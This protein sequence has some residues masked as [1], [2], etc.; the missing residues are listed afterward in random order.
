MEIYADNGATTRLSSAALDAMLPFLK[1]D[2]G[3]PSSI[4]SFG[5][6][7]ADALSRARRTVAGRLGA[8][9]DEIYFNSGG[10]ESITQ[11]I[12][13]AAEYGAEHG[14]RHIITT[15]I[16]H[17]AVLN[18]LKRLGRSGFEI[19]VLPVG[20]D[21]TVDPYS[22]RDTIRNDTALVSVMFANNEIG[23]VQPVREIGRICRERG[24]LFHTDAVQATGH[25]PVNA[26]DIGADYISAS[27]HKF[28]G[29]KGAGILFA[30]RGA[31]V[32]E[33]IFGGPQ[34][35]GARAG[36]ENVPAVVGA[37]A[38][39]EEACETMD[40]NFR[41]VTS[42]RE[43]LI[44][45]L[46]EIPGTILNGS[47]QKRLPGN[48]N[49]SFPGI[50]GESLVILLDMKGIKVSAGSACNSVSTEPSYVL[51]AIG[52]STDEALGS[53]RFTPDEGNTPE[54]IDLIIYTVKD[55][56]DKLR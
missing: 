10:S 54:E 47:R 55:S 20:T 41:Y 5:I 24:V 52:R 11:A 6:K 28:H 32:S 9:E 1:D 42:L 12:T 53:V 8:L 17:H 46:L 14:K 26:G 31:P 44:D 45:G 18:A 35:R 22:V 33:I 23:T 13:S 48:V 2:F 50:S 3:N 56:L 21:G 34:E 16:E 39:L 15:A 43:K 7:A 29:P 40:E 38:A 30:R 37:A 36:T 4:H 49:V 25:V 51:T 27:A 19:T